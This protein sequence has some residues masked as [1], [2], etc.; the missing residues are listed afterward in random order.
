MLRRIDIFLLIAMIGLCMFSLFFVYS[1]SVDIAGNVNS[2]EFIRQLFFIIL[3]II[4]FILIQFVPLRFI[5]RNAIW[6]YIICVLLL[7][8]T[9]MIGEI[10]N[11]AKSWLPLFGFSIQ[12]S[13]FMKVATILLFATVLNEYRPDFTSLKQLMSYSVIGVFPMLLILIQPDMGTTLVYIPIILGIYYIYGYS[14]YK[15]IF[16]IGIGIISVVTLIV[17]YHFN[18]MDVLG[19]QK[20]LLLRSSRYIYYL[21]VLII[22]CILSLLGFLTGYLHILFK[23]ICYITTMFGVGSVLAYVATLVLKPYQMQRLLVFVNPNSDP[24][25][26]GWHILQSV[27]AIG[28]GGVSGKG[29]LQGTHTKL[30]FLPQKSTDFIFSV[31]GEEMGLIGGGLLIL[32]YMLII[33]RMIMIGIRSNDLWS[34]IYCGGTVAM[35]FTHFLVNVGMTLGVMP[36]TGIPLLLVS[37]GG[38]SLLTSLL[39][40]AIVH[41]IYASNKNNFSRVYSI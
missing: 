12:S 15:V 18:S 5:I 20:I 11:G 6:I 9:L 19:S 25:G 23:S 36:V 35:F 40:I 39:A 1:S 33:W 13:E 26:S 37:Y 7:L 21:A 38:S 29:Y 2:N 8:L 17:S 3:G 4:L 41:N 10:R 32:L 34:S 31:I 16:I 28:A 24:L 30:E 22:V 14:P 27:A